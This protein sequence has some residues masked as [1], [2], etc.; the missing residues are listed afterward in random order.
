[1]TF[2]DILLCHASEG[3]HPCPSEK[4]NI[5]QANQVREVTTPS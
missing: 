3:W 1:M 5:A 4:P 2:L